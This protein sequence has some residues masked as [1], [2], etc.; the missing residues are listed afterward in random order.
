MPSPNLFYVLQAIQVYLT[1]KKSSRRRDYNEMIETLK[2][3]RFENDIFF[4]TAYQKSTKEVRLV[5]GQY[6]S[7]K[8]V[9]V[10]E[11][12]EGEDRSRAD[13]IN[14]LASIPGIDPT[15]A[16]QCFERGWIT[17]RD[18]VNK[19][20]LS[21]ERKMLVTWR[22]HIKL[23]IQDDDFAHIQQRV[24]AIIAN[25]GLICA[26]F[27]ANSIV[28]GVPVIRLYISYREC[29]D[30]IYK[31][32]LSRLDLGSTEW[33]MKRLHHILPAAHQCDDGHFLAIVQ[34]APKLFPAHLAEIYFY[35]PDV[36][37][38]EVDYMQRHK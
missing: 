24:G 14:V 27:K 33:I 3:M 20:D 32:I 38:A 16:N 9:T 7:G 6:F 23:T 12:L 11:L 2:H 4:T 17:L 28:E 30:D 35:P 26:M 18:I 29:V 5:V 8:Y 1:V 31:V 19:S 21:E 22:N 15:F 34:V 10:L 36:Y 13:I 25:M 37:Y